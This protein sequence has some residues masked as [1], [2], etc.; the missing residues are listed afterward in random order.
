MPVA[1]WSRGEVATLDD[2]LAAAERIGYPLMLKATAGGGGRGIRVITS[3]RRPDRRVRAHQPGGAARVRQRHR[4]PGAAGHRR[5]ARRG[6]GDR[7]RAGHGLGA[8]RPRL[9]GA[10]AQPE[11]HRGVGLAGPG[12]GAGR[13]AEGVGRAAGAGRRLPRRGDRRVPL[14]P[15]AA[16]GSRSSRSTPGCRSSTRSPSSPPAPTWSG[17]SCTW[18]RAGSSTGRSRPSPGTPSR[19]G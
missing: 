11:D 14:P 8:R 1:P 12:A 19:P 2:A 5:P 7:R 6:P 16:S 9:L 4:V 18:R 3:R 13:G 10:A 15:R 17:S